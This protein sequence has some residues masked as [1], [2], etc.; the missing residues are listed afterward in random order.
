MSETQNWP[1]DVTKRL[2]G[3]AEKMNVTLEKATEAFAAWLKKE[4]E[5]EDALAEDPFYLS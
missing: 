2:Q 3:Y 1:D 4:F 5:V